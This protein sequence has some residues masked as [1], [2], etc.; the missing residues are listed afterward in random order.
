MSLWKGWR[1]NGGLNARG[2]L[3]EVFLGSVLKICVRD[4]IQ[5][6]EVRGKC[7]AVTEDLDHRST[8]NCTEGVG[9]SSIQSMVPSHS[10]QKP[11]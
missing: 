5:A 11:M 1:K 6:D 9:R 8:E 2:K 10:R 4:V 3:K 7:E